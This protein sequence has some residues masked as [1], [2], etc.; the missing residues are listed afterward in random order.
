M[1]WDFFPWKCLGHL[2]C[3]PLGGGVGH[4]VDPNQIASGQADDDQAVQQAKTD[5]RNH[6]QIEC[7]NVRRMIAKEC[8]PTLWWR[9]AALD[10]VFGDVDC[11]ISNPS[12][13]NSP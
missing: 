6:E 13:S 11:A 8:P 4:H 1:S 5:G 12:L 10:Y 9:A 7:C 2:P 3:H